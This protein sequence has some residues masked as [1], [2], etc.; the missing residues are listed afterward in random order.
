MFYIRIYFDS[1]LVKRMRF[2]NV[3]EMKLVLGIM[4]NTYKPK[5]QGIIF[6]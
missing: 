2:N 5:I 4:T 3:Y 6:E 1:N